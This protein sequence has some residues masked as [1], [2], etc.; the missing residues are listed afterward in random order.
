MRIESKRI[1]TLF[2]FGGIMLSK[3]KKFAPSVIEQIQAGRFQAQ[4]ARSLGVSKQ[5]M[6]NWFIKLENK[7]I[8][9]R[10]FRSSYSKYKVVQMESQRI[11]I[12]NGL[13]GDE[14]GIL[15]G[16]ENYALKAPVINNESRPL[17]YYK[18]GVR[19]NNN[20]QSFAKFGGITVR[21]LPKT[22]VFHYKKLI[23]DSPNGVLDHA[24]ADIS[25]LKDQLELDYG[26]V[27][28]EL[29]PS[30]KPE[31]VPKGSKS[32][33]RALDLVGKVA[34]R[35]EHGALNSSGG[36]GNEVEFFNKQDALEWPEV[37]NSIRELRARVN[38]FE[39]I[40][41]YAQKTFEPM[42]GNL[43]LLNRAL[44]EIKETQLEILKE[45]KARK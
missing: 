4:I 24:N 14:R 27:L 20:E 11:L 13:G 35:T 16:L 25:A 9:R 30:R 3:F 31:F 42:V 39:K 36:A 19:F 38:E 26:L 6:A 41:F 8:I 29:V 12:D 34:V 10:E 44:L 45:L 23:G 32:A 2:D 18:I 40:A 43:E 37:P 17:P 5:T 15:Y 28:G 21:K 33:L 22:V 1:L 7:G